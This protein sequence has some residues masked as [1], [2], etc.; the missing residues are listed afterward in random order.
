MA[1]PSGSGRA[2]GCPKDI[3]RRADGAV[4]TADALVAEVMTRM[5]EVFAAERSNLEHQWDR[6]DKVTTEDLRVALQRIGRFSIDF[7]RVMFSG[8]MALQF[9]DGNPSWRSLDARRWPPS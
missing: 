6:G 1:K 8:R 2:G 3:R 5:A 9:S 4:E 7:D